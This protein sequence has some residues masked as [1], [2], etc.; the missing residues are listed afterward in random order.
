MAGGALEDLGAHRGVGAGV[1]D[2]PRLDRG[3]A[4]LGVAA[5]AVAHGDGVAFGVDP[6]AL[7]AGQDDLDGLLEEPGGEGGV[8]LDREI[9]LAAEGAAVGH[10]FDPHPVGADAQ[11]G[12]DLALV[13]VDPLALGVDGEPAVVG[14]DRERGLGFEKGVLDALGPELGLHRVGGGGQRGLDIA[15]REGADLEEIAAV[16]D[17]RCVRSPAPA[18]GSVTGS[19]TSTW[20]STCSAARRA[21]C[22][23]S[24]TTTARTSPM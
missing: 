1:A 7:L 22:R 23:V 21:W 20:T 3:E 17:R 12:G 24:A 13:V 8:A 19:S 2:H 11:D 15:A 6:Q 5:G 9:L 18:P 16:V 4:S 14:G 10:Q